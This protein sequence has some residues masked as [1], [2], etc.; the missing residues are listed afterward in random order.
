MGGRDDVPTHFHIHTL[1]RR[2][3]RGLALLQPET[4]VIAPED[5]A[6]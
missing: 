3:D 6:S 2:A 5:R 1:S 4:V